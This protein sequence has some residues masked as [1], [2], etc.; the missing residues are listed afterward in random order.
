M[1]KEF[2]KILNKGMHE[3]FQSLEVTPKTLVTRRLT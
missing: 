2:L 1:A 3:V